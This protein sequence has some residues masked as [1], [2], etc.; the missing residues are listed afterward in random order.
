METLNAVV[1]HPQVYL[2]L[3][4]RVSGLFLLAPVFGNTGVPMLVRV[5]L[6]LLV[7]W[8]LFPIYGLTLPD[9]QVDVLS[10]VTALGSELAIGL[11]VGMVA[12]LIL[13]TFQM[14]GSIAGHHIGFSFLTLF[15]PSQREHSAAIDQFYSLFGMLLFLVINGHHLL[16]QAFDRTFQAIPLG[17]AIH[18]DG[19]SM[20]L[21]Q[22]ISQLFVASFQLSLPIVAAILLTDVALGLVARAVPQVNVL[23]LGF[24][25]KVIMGLTALSL[26]LPSVLTAMEAHV[27]LGV[28]NMVNI[29]GAL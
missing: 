3:V 13:T 16:L 24:P 18:L 19:A 1:N 28:R 27:E 14:A 5:A 9:P 4:A 17:G 15:D 10:L 12:S 26:A 20:P 22:L 25:L 7:G 2:L 8:V 23:F 21:G 11:T 6:V 29:L